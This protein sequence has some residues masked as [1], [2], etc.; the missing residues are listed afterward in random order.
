MHN[1]ADTEACTRVL[2]MRHEKEEEAL[3]QQESRA[4]G[5]AESEERRLQ[6]AVGTLHEL[7]AI[8]ALQGCVSCARGPLMCAWL[9]HKISSWWFREPKQAGHATAKQLLLL[10]N[11]M[12]WKEGVRL[13]PDGQSAPGSA[14]SASSLSLF[15]LH[16]V[17]CSKIWKHRL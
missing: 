4:A 11:L 5:C 17:S 15:M 14:A 6:A 3:Q 8:V 16:M 7:K 1:G 9:D 12:G 2:K 13:P 10:Q